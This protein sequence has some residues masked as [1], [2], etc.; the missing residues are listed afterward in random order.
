MVSTSLPAPAAD[1]IPYPDALSA[2]AVTEN[3]IAN[4]SRCG[5]VIGNG[6]INA[7]VYSVGDDIRLRIG[8]NDCWD[9]RVDTESDPPLATINPATG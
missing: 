4:I 2:A 8:K 5:L 7:I 3:S 9:L 1:N 6:E